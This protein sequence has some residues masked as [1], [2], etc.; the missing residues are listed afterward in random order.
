MLLLP[1]IAKTADEPGANINNT[2]IT[3]IGDGNPETTSTNIAIHVATY[4]EI[5]FCKGPANSHVSL[6]HW[7]C[8]YPN[9][10]RPTCPTINGPCSCHRSISTIINKNKNRRQIITRFR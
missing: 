2:G 1:I 5:R 4:A 6:V 8:K 9:V 10:N 7:N 3:D